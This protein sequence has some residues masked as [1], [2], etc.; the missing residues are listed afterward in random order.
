MANRDC[1]RCFP[2]TRNIT[3]THYI[4]LPSTRPSCCLLATGTR[5]PRMNGQ[6]LPEKIAYWRDSPPLPTISQRHEEKWRIKERWIRGSWLYWCFLLF[7]ILLTFSPT[8][9]I[10]QLSQD[11]WLLKVSVVSPLSSGILYRR[12]ASDRIQPPQSVGA[13]RQG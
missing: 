11:Y 5:F 6:I 9:A 4:P 8:S 2:Q 10:W 13:R 12:D 1:P 7:H 3:N